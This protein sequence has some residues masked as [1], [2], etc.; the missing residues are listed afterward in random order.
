[1]YKRQ[2]IYLEEF[3]EDLKTLEMFITVGS[4]AIPLRRNLYYYDDRNKM[5]PEVSNI[6]KPREIYM[7]E[8]QYSDGY[9]THSFSMLFGLNDIVSGNQLPINRWN[10]IEEKI[11]P[12]INLYFSIVKYDDMPI[13]M[14]YL[15]IVQAL[16]TYH[17]R[18][19]YNDLKKYKKHVL[20][21]FG[22]K[23]IEDIDE[24]Q[25]NVFALILGSHNT[26]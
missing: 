19:K 21:L 8:K 7:G 23:T 11:K 6:I 24:K 25:R 26:Y 3:I 1:M 14:K 12:A 9:E 5:F 10:E 2:P 22:S 18:F 17:A 16:E 20:Q 4:G 13:E 15:N